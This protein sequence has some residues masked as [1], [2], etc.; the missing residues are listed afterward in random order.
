MTIA[1]D[2]GAFAMRSLRRNRDEL[3]SRRCRSIAASIRES[4]ARRHWLDFAKVPYFR[5]EDYLVLPGSAATEADEL[6][7][8]IPRDLLPAGLL[9]IADPVAR[10]VLAMLVEGLLPWSEHR[11]EVCC[12]T[13]PGAPP[14]GIGGDSPLEMR[15]EFFARLIHLR[16][17]HPV[18]LNPATALV[19]A[20]LGEAG[21]SGIGVSLGAASCEIAVVHRGKQVAQ[22][23]LARGGRWIDEQF[24]LRAR[25]FRRDSFGEEVLDVEATRRRKESLTL[26]DAADGDS[27]LVADLYRNLIGELVEVLTE[28]LATNVQIPL[29]PRPLSIVCAGGPARIG[30]FCELFGAVIDRQPLPVSVT[31][32]HLVSDHEYA[33]ARG[34]LIWAELEELPR[35]DAIST[36]RCTAGI[37]LRAGAALC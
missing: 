2:P 28:T 10:Q 1:L 15:R 13:Q 29:L 34:C 16:G 6:F 8:T 30:G 36:S 17:Y 9:P 19:L 37:R 33:V 22:G 12:F 14:A 11:N 27:R 3:L 25:T 21:F 4:D 23:R 7:E 35:G 24:A 26:N 20:E 18:A 5:A 32:P 31:G